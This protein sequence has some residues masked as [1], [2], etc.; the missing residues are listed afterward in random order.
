[1][2]QTK[3]NLQKNE[4]TKLFNFLREREIGVNVHY[5]PI[6]LQP[7]YENL[8]GVQSLQGAEQYYNTCLSLPLFPRMSLQDVERVVKTIHRIL[9]KQDAV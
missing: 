8:Y 7:Y 4:R 9:K 6:H 5:I 3:E 2:I 1:M